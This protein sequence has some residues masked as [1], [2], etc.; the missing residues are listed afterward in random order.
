MKKVEAINQNPI[1][2]PEWK[3]NFSRLM[4]YGVLFV[5]VVSGLVISLAPK[6]M[7]V[8]VIVLSFFALGHSLVHGHKIS[9]PRNGLTIS[10]LLFIFWACLSTFWS[11]DPQKSLEKALQLIGFAIILT[12]LFTYARNMH[13]VQ[14]D[15][16]KALFV[17]SFVLAGIIASLI[18]FFPLKFANIVY[19]IGVVATTD[20]PFQWH[21]DSWVRVSN[22]GLSIL[23]MLG[24][25][26][27][28]YTTKYRKTI[29]FIA[30]PLLFFVI[31]SSQNQSALLAYTIAVLFYVFSKFQFNLARH[32]FR[33]WFVL[34]G[35][36][37][38]PLVQFN[39]DNHLVQK[40]LPEPLSGS[41]LIRSALYASYANEV[42]DKW[43][44]GDGVDSSTYRKIETLDEQV[45]IDYMK[46]GKAAHPHNLFLQ[47][48]VE[49]G[50]V[51]IF[52][53]N[54]IW[55]QILAS[56]GKENTKLNRSVMTA[57]LASIIVPFFAYDIWESWLLSGWIFC[58]LMIHSLLLSKVDKDAKS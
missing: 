2:F 17:F 49:L 29:L 19:G 4:D 11:L 51:G 16:V 53:L 30:A 18:V 20:S 35:L 52:L 56:I 26:V 45:L 36:C 32:L 44:V 50:A 8:I 13:A 25:I 33:A 38:V 14:R 43:L 12:A 9:L 54:I 55:F 10:L 42:D 48:W 5:F 39:Y 31:F 3:Q 7:T 58:G 46:K 27:V 47:I 22:G 57:T 37:I 28:A 1:D 6:G 23:T 21:M 24:F 34:M 15:R 41:S 40:Y